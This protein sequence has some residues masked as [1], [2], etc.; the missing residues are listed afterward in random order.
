MFVR[1][2]TTVAVAAGATLAMAAG[3]AAAHFCFKTELN[4]RAAAGMSGS[5]NWVSFGDLAAQVTGLCP[6]GVQ[7]LADA[8]G[9]TTD[10]LINGHGT[11]AGGTLRKGPDAGN[12]AISH[13]DFAAIEG[14]EEDAI[15]A[16]AD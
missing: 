8:A 3:P 12:K 16:C 2:I 14:A 13:L 15:A 1:R 5:A 4:E 10:T 6:A 9:V 7:V 11:M